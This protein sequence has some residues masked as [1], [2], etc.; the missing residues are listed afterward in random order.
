MQTLN[1]TEETAGDR[2]DKYLTETLTDTSRSDVQTRIKSG[3]I[4]VNGNIVKP[5]Y[6]L[7]ADDVI[8]VTERVVVESDIVPEDLDLNIVIF[9]DDV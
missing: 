1:I 6:K 3:N 2:L 7:K 5:N 8:E 9:I 4:T